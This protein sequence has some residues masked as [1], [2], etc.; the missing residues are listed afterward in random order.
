MN[1]AYADIDLIGCFWQKETDAQ[2]NSM[3][4]QILSA[5]KSIHECFKHTS[6]ILVISY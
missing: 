4:R 1:G 6:K 2:L 3:Q 5:T